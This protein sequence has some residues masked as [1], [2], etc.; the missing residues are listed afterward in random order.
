MGRLSNNLVPYYI[1]LLALVFRSPLRIV[2]H[3]SLN[4]RAYLR[5]DVK[6]APRSRSL[7]TCLQFTG[8]LTNLA[9]A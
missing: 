4:L 1:E 6:V 7:A 3:S 2:L 5:K 8:T 9:M